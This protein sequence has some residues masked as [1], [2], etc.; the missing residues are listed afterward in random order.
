MFRG[1]FGKS[2]IFAGF[3][4]GKFFRRVLWFHSTRIRCHV[5]FRSVWFRFEEVVKV[6]SFGSVK[7]GKVKF[8]SFGSSENSGNCSGKF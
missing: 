5:K 7:S 2:C 8:L 4:V 1:R 3:L 6:L